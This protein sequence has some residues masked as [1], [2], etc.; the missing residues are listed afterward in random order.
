MIKNLNLALGVEVTYLDKGGNMS[1]FLILM[2]IYHWGSNHQNTFIQQPFYSQRCYVSYFFRLK[3]YKLHI[4]ESNFALSRP[5]AIGRTCV[6]SKRIRENAL[7]MM[8]ILTSRLFEIRQ[9]ANN[10]NWTIHDYSRIFE[11]G[12]YTIIREYPI[13]REF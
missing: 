12:K 7:K 8:E 13:F 9:F 1:G 6:G 4:I 2:V 10:R 11:I 5:K 3:Y